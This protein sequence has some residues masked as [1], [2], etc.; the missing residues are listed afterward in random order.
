MKTFVV[1]GMHRSATSLAAKGLHDSGVHMG[2]EFLSANGHNP[3]GYYENIEFVK[4]ND[5]ILE[6]AGGSWFMPPGETAIL[7]QYQ[8]FKTR[9]EELVKKSSDGYELWGWKNPRTTLTIDL[10]LSYLVNP[11]FITCFRDK[12]EVAESLC[13]RDNFIYQYAVTLVEEYNRRLLR[14]LERFTNR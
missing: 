6:A 4:L 13:K 3:Q 9:I 5:D 10:Y 7:L 8:N 12:H 1:L 11:H 2:E 14:F